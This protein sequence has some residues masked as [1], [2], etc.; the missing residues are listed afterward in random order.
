MSRPNK[1]IPQRRYRPRPPLTVMQQPLTREVVDRLQ[2]HMRR[3]GPRSL[4]P[5]QHDAIWDFLYE[6]PESKVWLSH[7]AGQIQAGQNALRPAARA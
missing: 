3:H 6:L 1:N 5:R 7:M 2:A 4:T